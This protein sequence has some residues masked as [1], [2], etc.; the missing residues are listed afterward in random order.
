MALKDIFGKKNV[1]TMVETT[2]K[3]N[4]EVQDVNTERAKDPAFPPHFIA[5]PLRP[6]NANVQLE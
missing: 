1:K 3:T 6:K 5:V 2:V 4:V